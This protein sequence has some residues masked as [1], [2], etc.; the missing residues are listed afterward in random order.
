MSTDFGVNACEGEIFSLY[1]CY[2]HHLNLNMETKPEV[3]RLKIALIENGKTSRWLAQQL[4]VNPTTV[5]KW[6]TNTSQPS[7]ETII[8]ISELLNIEITD[9]LAKRIKTRSEV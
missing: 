4:D 1:L 2:N 7:L 5:S 8:K 3:N 6:C 9:L